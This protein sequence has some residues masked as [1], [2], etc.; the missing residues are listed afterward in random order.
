MSWTALL[1]DDCNAL[2]GRVQTLRRL[3]EQERNKQG[4]RPDVVDALWDGW[5]YAGAA[6]QRQ[7]ETIAKLCAPWFESD[8]RSAA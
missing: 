6:L 2:R 7:Q 8:S 4:P 1:I 5:F 3:Y